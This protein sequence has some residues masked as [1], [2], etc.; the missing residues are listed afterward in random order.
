MR[1]IFRGMLQVQSVLTRQG[2]LSW[3]HDEYLLHIRSAHAAG[4]SPV[5]ETPP[6]NSAVLSVTE[7]TSGLQRSS[8][9]LSGCDGELSGAKVVSSNELLVRFNPST[10]EHQVFSL[11]TNALLGTIRKAGS[12]PSR[13]SVACEPRI[14]NGMFFFANEDNTVYALLVRK[15]HQNTQGSGEKAVVISSMMRL[16]RDDR[17][18][19]PK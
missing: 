19:K 18:D 12:S 7:V 11:A 6:S 9:L 13:T 16:D 2:P 17:V 3:Q 1:R 5:E 15:M 4:D 8:S 10:G 14:E